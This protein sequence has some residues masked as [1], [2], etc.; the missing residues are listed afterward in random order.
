MKIALLND[1]HFGA[2]NDSSIFDEYFYKFYDDIFFPYLK[3]HNIKTLIHLGD[4]VDRRKY[5]NY[6]IAHNLRHKFLNRL[7]ED[8]IDTHILIGN[9]DIYYRNTNKVNA[10]KELCTAADGV[11]E[12]WIYE[13]P[14]V[15]DFD[16]LKILMMPW[17]NPENE[18]DSLHTLNTAEADICMGHFDLN[19]FRMMDSIVQTHGYDKKIVSRFETT[20][21]GHF[22]HKND[23]GQVFYLG[24]QYEMTWSDYNNQKGFHVLDTE[25]REV[26]FIPNP[27]TIFKKLMYN[28]TETNYDK[29]D[30]SDY[31]QKFI[32]L[33]VVN[34]KDNQMFDRLLDR[35]YNNISVH[36][37]KILED[38][39]D[40]SHT[41]V[42]DDV[43]EGSED[44]ITLVNN[45][46]DQL[47]VDLDKE[48]LKVMIKEKFIEAQDSDIKDDSI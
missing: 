39:S 2:R 18:A 34:K 6:R 7:W 37:L 46:V 36:E 32:K 14:K 45:Y 21:S 48:K 8:K 29:M 17:I 19:G 43:V 28:D 15:V 11:N 27:H 4:I 5:I 31:N 13:D 16:G 10:V 3:Q 9:H 25:T 44:T 33:V 30:I 38:Y 24:S 23:D 42:S 26:E 47:P 1:T 20:Y 40:L 35:L 41:N 22:H 12:P